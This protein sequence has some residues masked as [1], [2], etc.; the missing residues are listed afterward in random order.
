MRVP[1]MGWGHTHGQLLCGWGGGVCLCAPVG[2]VYADGMK[3]THTHTE[4]HKAVLQSSF[5]SVASSSIPFFLAPAVPGAAAV[6]D[7]WR[8][9]RGRSGRGDGTLA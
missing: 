8:Q 7:L 1:G 4:T 6:T 3:K 5:N 9:M 2:V